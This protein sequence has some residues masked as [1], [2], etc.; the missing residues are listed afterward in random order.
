MHE[1]SVTGTKTHRFSEEDEIRGWLVETDDLLP[2]I[3]EESVPASPFNWHKREDSLLGSPGS[4][5]NFD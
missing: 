2:K 1:Q 3:G 5:G 4:R